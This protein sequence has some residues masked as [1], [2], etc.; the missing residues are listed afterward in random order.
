MHAFNRWLGILMMVLGA[1][2]MAAAVILGIGNFQED[3]SAGVSAETALP[4]VIEAIEQGK[5]NAPVIYYNE[6]LEPVP[7]YVENPDMELPEKEILNEYY[8]GLLSFPSL[9]LELPVISEFSYPALQNAPCRYL[10]TPYQNHLV[11]C[12]HN[13][14]SHFRRIRE[15]VPGDKILFVDLDG[16]EFHYLVAET[17]ILDGYDYDAMMHSDW[18]LTLF[19]CTFD[20]SSRVTVRCILEDGNIIVTE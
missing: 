6:A 12:A 14:E 17:E 5:V 1:G 15:L 13:Y 11:I 7:A 9:G 18:P 16:N 4:K 19:T 3:R 2:A 10:G 8:C 20:S